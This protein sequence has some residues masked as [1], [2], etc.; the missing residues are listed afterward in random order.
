MEKLEH[1]K[2][3]LE[4]FYEG[5]S[6]L[7]EEQELL[8]YFSQEPV[9]DELLPDK[10]LFEAM[11]STSGKPVDVPESLNERILSAI[12]EVDEKEVRVRR[13]SWL[14]LSGLAAGLLVLLGIYFMFLREEPSRNLIAEDTY[15]DPMMAYR[16]AKKALSFVSYKF[17]QGTG[18]LQPLKEVNETM[19]QTIQPITKI[20][21]GSKQLQLLGKF[22]VSGETRTH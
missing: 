5:E 2:K 11:R 20:S 14:S 15:E 12:D 13:V 17:N 3:L 1:I 18:E 19:Q 22:D 21:S 16:E 9:P 7:T 6:T 4:R 10:E 8:D